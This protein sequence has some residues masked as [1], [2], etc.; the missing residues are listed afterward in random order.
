MKPI[1]VAAEIPATFKDVQRDSLWLMLFVNLFRVLFET[2]PAAMSIEFVFDEN[3]KIAKHAKRCT[4]LPSLR[5]ASTCGK[6][7]WG[8]TFV[9]DIDAL[10]VQAAD[11]LM[12]ERS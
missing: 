12:S 9:P 4:K 1:G 7:P 6:I 2:D 11:F 8:V 10:Q 5:S 3:K